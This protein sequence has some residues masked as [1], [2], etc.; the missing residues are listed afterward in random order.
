M[1]SEDWHSLMDMLPRAHRTEYHERFSR[2]MHDYL[3][4]CEGECL[5]RREELRK[6]VADSLHHF[7]E[8]RYMLGGFVVMPNHVHMLVQ[9]IGTT[10]LKPMCKSWKRFTARAIHEQIGR[11]GH[12]WQ[13]ETYDHIVRSEAQFRH[14][15]EYMMQNPRN[16]RLR[17]NE[18]TVFMPEWRS[19]M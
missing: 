12:Y 9:F 17:E 10:R 15:R 19:E 18:F 14:Y 5:L 2:Q 1:T 16:A 13:S 8:E 6:F 11:S 3:D 4:R 7:D